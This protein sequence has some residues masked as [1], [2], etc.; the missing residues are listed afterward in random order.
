MNRPL[1]VALL[2][3]FSLL[4]GG[5]YATHNRAGEI[6]WER[7]GTNTIRCTLTTYTKFEGN[8]IPAD[9]DS[10]EFDWGDGSPL[11][12]VRRVNG[13]IGAS[14]VPQGD[15]VRPGLKRNLYIAEHTYPGFGHF[16]IGFVDPNRIADICNVNDPNSVTVKFYIETTVT[17]VNE[18]FGAPNNSPLLFQFPID[19]ACVGQPFKHNPGAFDPDGDSLAFRLI[20]PLEGA[21]DE[22]PLYEF[23][24]MVEP[25]PMNN[26]SINPVTGD[27]LWDAP[28]KPCIYNIAILVIDYRNGQPLDSV[29]RDM[30]IIVEEC[31]N[32]PP[33]IAS[34][35][36]ICVIAGETVEFDVVAT[37]PDQNP[38]QSVLLTAEGAPL[39]LSG[40]PAT[41]TVPSDP[42]IPPVVGIFSWQ[43]TCEDISDQP[44]F[45]VFKAVD[46]HPNPLADLKTVSIRV[47]GP[48]PEDMQAEAETGEV[49]VSW[50]LPYSCEEAEDEYFR[51]FSV[52]RR[53][54]SNPFVVDSC[55]PGLAGKGYIRVERFYQGVEGG[56]YTYRDAEVER[57]RTYCY[58]VLAEFARQTSLGQN[59]N[60][61]EGLASEEVCVQ[62]ARDVPLLTNVDV[63]VTDPAS[64]RI[65][66]RWT[67]PVADDLD[68]LQNPG[69]YRFRLQR[70]TG[71]GTDNFQPVPGAD[72]SSPT[73]AGLT[74][75]F[76]IDESGLNTLDNPYTYKID[77]FV[78]GGELIENRSTASSVFLSIASS[79]NTNTLSWEENVPWINDRYVVY[80]RN[81]G[82][83]TFDSIGITPE[84]PFADEG[85]V[86]GEEYC[87]YVQAIGTYGI[88]SFP[89]SL[90]NRSQIACGIPIDTMPP[91]APELEVSNEC[92]DADNLTPEEE[93]INTLVWT[94]PNETCPDTDDAVAYNLY[95]AAFPDRPLELFASIDDVNQLTFQHKPEEGIAGCYAVTAVDS[96]DNESAIDTIVCVE[97][98][99]FYELPNVFTPNGDGQNE[100]FIPFPYRFIDRIELQVYNRWGQL[101]F[102]TEDPDIN[103]DGT[104]LSGEPVVEGTYFYTCKLFEKRS[105]GSI[106]RQDIL[107]GFVE[108]IRGE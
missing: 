49:V 11:E 46:D 7:I 5:L 67:R 70:S 30:Q 85:L 103:W 47:V 92:N 94:N 87:Y 54:G 81:P 73:F 99:P 43:T 32:R 22:V 63:E 15:F 37:D 25:G 19:E 62:L 83:G 97:N 64:G 23:P 10:V 24:N 42:A 104:N 6:T 40:N 9:R 90:I 53:E 48:P 91:C 78:N 35:D 41:F 3:I 95:F 58:R 33:E 61:V 102:K 59:F 21:R 38:L 55:E 17:L 29:I 93:F 107:S 82:A 20:A 106:P 4:A 16:R 77:F 39:N 96:F 84:P 34:I 1:R 51:G 76:F 89:D 71:L 45:V 101:V 56:R 75:T 36:E 8:A 68:T 88:P 108:I 65:F 28:Q 72:F 18:L 27:I 100:R 44:Y 12:W 60:N 80:R 98:C 13:P 2:L 69:P 31:D 79:D 66:V 26:L 105:G 74:D 86:N 52:W 57:G 14:G 50:E